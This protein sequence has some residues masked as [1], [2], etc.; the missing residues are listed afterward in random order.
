MTV[1]LVNISMHAVLGQTGICPLH[2]VSN[3]MVTYS[4][5]E[6]PPPVGIVAT[7]S[8]DTGYDLTGNRMRICEETTGWTGILPVCNGQCHNCFY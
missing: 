7:Y 5:S 1:S 6:E 4:K 2:T 8:C 3:G